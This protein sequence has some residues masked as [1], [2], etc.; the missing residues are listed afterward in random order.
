MNEKFEDL[1][2]ELS[3]RVLY[4]NDLPKI[5][6]FC[7]LLN[8]MIIDFDYK[9]D[10]ID[11]FILAVKYYYTME[12]ETALIYTNKI[13][14]INPKFIRAY[15]L[16]A[17]IYLKLKHYQEALNCIEEGLD[18]EETKLLFYLRWVFITKH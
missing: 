7:D 4:L 18:I 16:K 13:L 10:E 15:N 9:L 6:E 14:E 12:L 2:F 3:S 8:K 17:L 1:K 11:Y 5:N